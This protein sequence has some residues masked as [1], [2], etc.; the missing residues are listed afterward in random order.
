M[1]PWQ[2]VLFVVVMLASAAFSNDLFIT[3]IALYWAI[4][5]VIL[6]WAAKED[7]FQSTMKEEESDR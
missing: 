6:Y 3:C 2:Y 5:G 1:K 7:E 4:W